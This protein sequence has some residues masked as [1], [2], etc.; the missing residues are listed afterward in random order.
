MTWDKIQNLLTAEPQGI[1][2]RCGVPKQ[3][4]QTFCRKCYYALSRPEQKALYKLVG[5]GYEEAYQNAVRH[6]AA[7]GRVELPEWMTVAGLSDD[8]KRRGY[9]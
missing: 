7:L 1:H 5:K 4:R 2:C 9:Q 8:M 6:L 3:P